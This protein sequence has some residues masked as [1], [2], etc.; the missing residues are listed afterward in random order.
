MKSSAQTLISYD[1]KTRSEI[2]DGDVF[3]C[4][5]NY[6]L[7][8]LYEKFDHTYYSHA[9][10]GLWWGNRLMILQAEPG[11]GIQA[12]PLSSAVEKYSG[13]VDWYTLNKESFKPLTSDD[14]KQRLLKVIDEATRVL[15][16]EYGYINLVR[17]LL[18][19][20]WRVKLKDPV[21]PRAM[22]CSEYVEHCFRTGDLSLTGKPAIAT[23]PKHLEKCGHL[24]KM[25]TLEKSAS[26]ATVHARRPG[27]STPVPTA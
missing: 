22:F 21:R 19:W 10:V 5:G 15:G 24:I 7:S 17:N 18:S 20:I 2:S 8:E 3:L 23:F 12:L 16:D 1:D 25:G 4:K 6:F 9:A 26:R 14:C 13:L 27:W 11:K